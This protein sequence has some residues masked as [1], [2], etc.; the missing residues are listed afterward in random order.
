MEHIHFS[1]RLQL[2]Q[3]VKHLAIQSLLQMEMRIK[4]VNLAMHLAMAASTMRKKMTSSD[5]EN[6]LRGILTSTCLKTTALN[7]AD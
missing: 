4:Y 1:W 7:H 2:H 3:R 6:V 5:A